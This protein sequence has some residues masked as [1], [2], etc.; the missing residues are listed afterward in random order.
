MIKKLIFSFCFL[1]S[2]NMPGATLADFYEFLPAG[3]MIHEGKVKEGISELK[4]TAP[5]NEFA[6]VALYLIYS[7]GYCNITADQQMAISKY[8]DPLLGT[9]FRSREWQI[10]TQKRFPPVNGRSELILHDEYGHYHA[11]LQGKYPIA[12]CYEEKMLQIGG[13]IPRTIFE[14][15]RVGFKEW[16]LPMETAREMGNAAAYAWQPDVNV[17]KNSPEFAEHV[18]GLEKAAELSHIPSMICLAEIRMSPIPKADYRRA[19]VLLQMAKKELKRY[20]AISCHHAALELQKCE[21]LLKSLPDYSR[22]SEQLIEDRSNALPDSVLYFA[23]TEEL[24]RRNDNIESAFIRIQP[25]LK[26]PQKQKELMPEVLKLAEKGCRGAIFFLLQRAPRQMQ[27]QGFYFAGKASLRYQ[28]FQTPQHCY[29]QALKLLQEFRFYPHLLSPQEYKAQL[30]LLGEVYPSA[31]ACYDQEFPP[32]SEI[33]RTKTAFP[34]ALKIKWEETPYGKIL[35]LYVSPCKQQNYFELFLKPAVTETKIVIL[36]LHSVNGVSSNEVW[37]IAGFAD[38]S[39]AKIYINDSP[40][41]KKT[42]VRL[43]INIAPTNRSFELRLN[44]SIF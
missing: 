13:V 29:E 20:S 40:T 33:I 10:Y 32:K 37:G 11:K 12:E 8:F 9:F 26:N 7:R 22:T 4:K 6:S 14:V 3:R 19:A 24:V 23:I 38:G 17:A 5:R 42:P 16:K 25:Q 35:K 2:L 43:R 27:A 34:D 30:Q 18:K 21:K 39:T 41:L 28:E 36:N 44:G 15:A 31:K 1:L